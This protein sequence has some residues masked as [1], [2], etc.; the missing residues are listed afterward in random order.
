MSK[1]LVKHWFASAYYPQ[2]AGCV[3]KTNGIL[4][5]IIDKMIQKTQS[6][7]EKWL[8]MALWAYHTTFKAATGYSPFHLV[9]GIEAILPIELEL[10]TLRIVVENEL[11]DTEACAAGLIMLERLDEQRREA[12]MTNE[13]TQ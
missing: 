13:A 8:P 12:L 5:G 11:D 1:L 3:E 9:C 4:C 2:C 6:E 10:P 7:W